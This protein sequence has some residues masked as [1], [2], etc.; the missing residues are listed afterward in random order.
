MPIASSY[1]SIKKIS[2]SSQTQKSAVD[3]LRNNNDINAILPTIAYILELKN[4]CI[5]ELP[6]MFKDCEVLQYK[7]ENLILSTPN[8]ALASKLKQQLPRL[9][10]RLLAKNWGINTIQIKVQ[11]QKNLAKVSTFKQKKLSE[12]AFLAFSSLIQELKLSISNEPLKN[13]VLKMIKSHEKM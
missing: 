4:Q 1:S 2:F 9:R 8:A 5:A 13:A 10:K 7:N 12:V 11:V 3:F 6:L